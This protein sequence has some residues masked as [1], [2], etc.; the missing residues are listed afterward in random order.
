VRQ[1][2]I[3]DDSS[4]EI[5]S[6][7]RPALD[8]AKTYRPMFAQEIHYLEQFQDCTTIPDTSSLP[9]IAHLNRQRQAPFH[10]APDNRFHPAR[11]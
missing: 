2:A 1:S 4:L 8:L 5:P 3:Y 6:L 9:D 10:P 11:V 7:D